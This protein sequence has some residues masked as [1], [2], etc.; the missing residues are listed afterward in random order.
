MALAT[1]LPRLPH[2]ASFCLQCMFPSNPSKQPQLDLLGNC[3]YSRLTPLSEQYGTDDSVKQIRAAR[4]GLR[5][6]AC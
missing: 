4:S 5:T 2:L 1:V 3:T 6:L